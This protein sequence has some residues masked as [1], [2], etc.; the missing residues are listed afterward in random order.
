MAYVGNADGRIH[1][2][3]LHDGGEAWSVDLGG[4]VTGDP[5]LLDGRLFV[6]LADGR[7]VCLK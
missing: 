6:G 3:D 2:I 1:R 5:V 4:P 7:L